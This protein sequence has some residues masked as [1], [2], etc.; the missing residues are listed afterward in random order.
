MKKVIIT[1]IIFGFT[2]NQVFALNND[3]QP[4]KGTTETTT[5]E[6]ISKSVI[7]L[8]PK[9]LEP[10]S[11]RPEEEKVILERRTKF[12]VSDENFQKLGELILPWY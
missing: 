2:V 1:A 7:N 8:L 9:G 6:T 12:Q 11:Y 3:N 10:K 5:E 4:K